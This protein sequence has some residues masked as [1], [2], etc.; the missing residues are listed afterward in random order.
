MIESTVFDPQTDIPKRL[1]RTFCG[2]CVLVLKASLAGSP[3]NR[4]G[5]AAWRIERLL[6]RHLGNRIS[7]SK[8]IENCSVTFLA[9]D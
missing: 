9:L 1:E 8:G 5:N 3:R 2:S 7:E 6:S 4:I